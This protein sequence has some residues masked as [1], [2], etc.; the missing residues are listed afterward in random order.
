[1]P[2]C[3]AGTLGGTGQLF[4]G[5]QKEN[6]AEL[7]LDSSAR[8][9]ALWRP[10][11]QAASGCGCRRLGTGVVCL[12]AEV[13]MSILRMGMVSVWLASAGLYTDR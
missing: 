12:G 9:A 13:R 5:G 1:M 10:V 2:A 3:S 7:S 8:G 11:R 4:S 6:S